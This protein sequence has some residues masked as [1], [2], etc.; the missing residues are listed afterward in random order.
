MKRNHPATSVSPS[1][2]AIGVSS[3]AKRSRSAA[4]NLQDAPSPP[5]PITGRR[6]APR[7]R[8]GH[9]THVLAGTRPPYPSGGSDL[10]GEADTGADGDGDGD[11]DAGDVQDVFHRVRALAEQT[12]LFVARTAAAAAAAGAAADGRAVGKSARRQGSTGRDEEAAV[13]DA[14][15]TGP[16][17]LPSSSPPPPLLSISASPAKLPVKSLPLPPTVAAPPPPQPSPQ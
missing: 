5:Q 16:P 2:A 14:G 3:T 4:S 11:A 17:Q 12:M 13:M 8:R 9:A 1:R 7:P 15:A 6:R 10:F